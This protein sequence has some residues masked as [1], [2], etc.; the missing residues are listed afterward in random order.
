MHSNYNAYDNKRL[1]RKM[2]NFKF[3]CA[4]DKKDQSLLSVW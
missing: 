4:T 3:D 1:F 2:Y